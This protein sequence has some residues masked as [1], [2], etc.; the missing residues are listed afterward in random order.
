MDNFAAHDKDVLAHDRVD[1]YCL[2]PNCIAIHQPMD[3]G[4][5]A[6]L[7]ARYRASLLARILEI[8]PERQQLRECAKNLPKGMKGIAE[9]HDAHV[10][11]AASILKD[12]W[13]GIPTHHILHCWVKA[14]VLPPT[15]SADLENAMGKVHIED[16]NAL[17]DF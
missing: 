3:V 14:N 12:S 2:P 13:E 8:L 1:V 17:G 10:L 15:H 11:D 5:I 4:V 16:V 9:G 6:A 7:K